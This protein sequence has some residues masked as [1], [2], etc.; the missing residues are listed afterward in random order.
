MYACNRKREREYEVGDLV[1]I[2]YLRKIYLTLIIAGIKKFAFTLNNSQKTS[3]NL[4]EKNE[5]K[6]KER[7][8]KHNNSLKVIFLKP[9][10]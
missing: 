3:K 5:Q 10:A 2:Y 9:E 6:E 1:V 4:L 8:K 7:K